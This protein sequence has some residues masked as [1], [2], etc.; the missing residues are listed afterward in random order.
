MS[1]PEAYFKA[2]EWVRRQTF[3]RTKSYRM[4]SDG[5]QGEFLQTLS[6]M[7]RPTRVLEIGTF[8]GYATLCLARGFVGREQDCVIDTFEVNDELRDLY[9][10]A[11]EMAG[12]QV[13][14]AAFTGP[15]DPGTIRAHLQDALDAA[16]LMDS[17]D[18]VYID[19]NKREYPAY[20]EAFASKVRPGGWL[21]ADN[22]L[23]N[24]LAAREDRPHDRQTEAIVAFN[25]ALAADPRFRSTILPIRD[26]LYVARRV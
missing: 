15:S 11:F 24:G 10:E 2:L 25:S 5:V 16:P 13:N 4:L 6:L 21:L 18:I 23:W 17:Y 14:P 19:A 3:L 8:S 9:L 12:F 20:L 22:V 26:G 7:A 1:S